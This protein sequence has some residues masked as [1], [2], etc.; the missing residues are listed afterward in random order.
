VVWSV[1]AC[2]DTDSRVKFDGFLKDL[3]A[4]KIEE[5]PIPTIVG[6]IEAPIPAEGQVY[7]Y[8]FEVSKLQF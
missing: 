2:V 7:D 3:M 8:L 6:K 5:H 1:G 4:G